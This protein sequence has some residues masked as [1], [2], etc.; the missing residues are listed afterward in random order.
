MQ[1]TP[2]SVISGFLGAGKTTLLRKIIAQLD[3]K[4]A[5]IMNEFGEI[6][7]DTHVI[8]GKNV[9]V[10]ELAGG[11]V[12]CSLIGEFQ[13]AVKEVIEKY[14]PEIIIVETTGVA[15][16]D[17]LI[18]DMSDNMKDVRI[19]SVITVADADGIL[20][21]AS[22]GR[23]G[24]VQIEMADVV[25]L[26]KVDLV[27][28]PQLDIIKQRIR[29]FNKKAPII[30]TTYCDV[31]IDLLF[32]LEIEH[33]INK[34]H[35]SQHAHF[36]SFTYTLPRPVD[37]EA[38]EEML[39]KLPP[40][41]YRLKGFVAFEEEGSHF[42]NYVAGRWELEQMGAEQNVLVF[43]GECILPQKQQIVQMLESL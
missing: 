12:C 10:V 36:D 13:D 15:E 35:A 31:D 7:I 32:S 41:V 30:E 42:L 11:C 39:V 2:I 33:H 23:T 14:H 17:A 3:R 40:A 25:L 38:F 22:I 28:P 4:F 5:I 9:D 20:R 19:D 8:Q 24:A 6:G 18:L 27:A 21:F 37:R 1:K 43:I 29:E 26:N 16:P 34:V